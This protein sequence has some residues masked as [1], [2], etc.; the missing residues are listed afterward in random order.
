MAHT[1]EM[2][3][4]PVTHDRVIFRVTAQ[5]TNGALLEFD[6]FLLAGYISPPEHVYPRQ[7]ERFEVISGSLGVRIDGRELVLRAGESVAVPSGTPHT[8]WNAGE[9]ET[10][11]LVAFQPALQTEAFFETMFALAR[12]GKTDS[13]GRPSL[14]QF[15]AGASRVWDVRDQATHL[16]AKSPVRGAWSAGSSA[17][18]PAALWS[19]GGSILVSS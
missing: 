18:I 3:D 1:G 13:Q 17:R 14:L 10:H 19:V 6:D 4:N 12:A 11:L 8:I 9:G 2:I 15:A 16:F 7:Q 5:D